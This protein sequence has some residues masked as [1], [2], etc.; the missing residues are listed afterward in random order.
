MQ[1]LLRPRLETP[2]CFFCHVILVKESHVTSLDYRSWEIIPPLDWRSRKVTLQ[3]GA[4]VK[5][6]I[7]VHV[8]A[9]NLYIRLSGDHSDGRIR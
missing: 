3:K 5:R 6:G 1:G 7:I 8:F 4:D 2:T 9:N